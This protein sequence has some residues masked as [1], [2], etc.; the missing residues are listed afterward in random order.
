MAERVDVLAYD[1]YANRP[2]SDRK[3]QQ[4]R[5]LGAYGLVAVLV[6]YG[7]LQAEL[8]SSAVGALLVLGV[9]Y[10]AFGANRSV[11]TVY[12]AVEAGRS[13]EIVRAH[14]V[15]AR[16]RDQMRS[17][18]VVV[19][20]GG[21]LAYGYVSGSLLVGAIGGGV[22][23]AVAYVTRSDPE[24]PRVVETDVHRGRAAREFELA[25]ADETERE[26]WEDGRDR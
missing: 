19:V 15:E 18:L 2:E 10:Y 22:V 16:K 3:R 9:R 21:V 5:S 1:R 12:R 14:E 7:V 26:E 20:V 25:D 4:R 13:E 24:L 6:A 17:A 23:G 11:E 8:L